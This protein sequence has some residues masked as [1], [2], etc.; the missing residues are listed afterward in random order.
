MAGRYLHSD[1]NP[2]MA[3]V[4]T[5]KAVDVCDIVGLASNTLVKASDTT[6]D[7][8]LLTTQKAFALLFLGISGQAKTTTQ[9]RVVGNSEDNLIR[10]DTTGEYEY[11]CD[12]ATYNVGN[13]VGPAKHPSSNALLDSKLAAVATADAAIG[14]VIRTTVA[15][16]TKVRIRLWSRVAPVSNDT[17]TY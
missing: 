2:V 10:V 16:A 17:D 5:A 12:A 8:N 6:W 15:S 13:F 11:D 14:V 3:V 4:A 9:S 7:T 1:T